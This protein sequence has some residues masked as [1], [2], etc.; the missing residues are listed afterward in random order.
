M[1]YADMMERDMEQVWAYEDAARKAA[2]DEVESK[3]A[4]IWRE[5]MTLSEM[6]SIEACQDAVWEQIKDRK[7]RMVDG[8][9]VKEGEG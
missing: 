9:F 1:D 2:K 3:M 6:T 8:M 5:D 4:Q 7:G